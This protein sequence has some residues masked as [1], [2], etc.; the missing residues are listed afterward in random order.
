MNTSGFLSDITDWYKQPF[1]S[2]GSATQWVLFVGLLII[3]VWFWH[4]IL[5][6]ITREI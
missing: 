5:L 1:A 3:A 4:I 6:F 2:S